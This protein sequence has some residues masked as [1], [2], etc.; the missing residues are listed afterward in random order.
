MFNL[1]R[2][3]KWQVEKAEDRHAEGSEGAE[4]QADRQRVAGLGDD[5]SRLETR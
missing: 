5:G 3:R 4:R 1:R 2:R